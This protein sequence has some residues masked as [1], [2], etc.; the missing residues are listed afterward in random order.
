MTK[1]EQK[2][3]LRGI[4]NQLD[5]NDRRELLA[6]I[7]GKLLTTKQSKELIDQCS[8]KFKSEYLISMEENGLQ[9]PE[10]EKQVMR[11]PEWVRMNQLID[12]EP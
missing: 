12:R 4:I 11:S 9:T 1:Q 2:D 3:V 5:N 10:E 7:I 6:S 8:E